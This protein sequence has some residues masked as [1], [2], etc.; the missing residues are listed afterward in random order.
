MIMCLMSTEKLQNVE[1]ILR[2]LNLRRSPEK[3][4]KEF[5]TNGYY[6]V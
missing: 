1:N 4:K 3:N 5:L 6:L 2:R